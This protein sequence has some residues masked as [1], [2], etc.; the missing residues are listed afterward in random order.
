MPEDL[1]A[2]YQKTINQQR[3]YLARLQ[4][5]FNQHCDEITTE[6]ETKLKG[7]PAGDNEARKQVH[8]EQKKKLDEALN[9][10][11]AEIDKSSRETRKEL[12]KINC[13]REESRLQELEQ[14]MQQTGT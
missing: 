7:L 11:R 14:L 2:L 6:A 1:S 3:D 9:H 10:L 13:E 5:A 8:E 4:E 12:E